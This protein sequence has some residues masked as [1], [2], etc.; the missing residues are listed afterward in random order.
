MAQVTRIHGRNE[1]CRI[2]PRVTVVTPTWQRHDLLLN[3]CIPS[4]QAQDYPSVEHLIIS[5][6]PDGA[7]ATRMITPWLHG[8]D[9]VWYRELPE[10]DTSEL[11]Y[12]HHARAYGCEIAQG[13]YITYCDDDDSLRPEHCRLLAAALD[14]NP[15]AGFAVSMMVSHGPHGESV[16]GAGPLAAGNV[17]T[18]MIM[19]RRG[20]LD[21]AT[22]DHTSSF[23]DWELVWAWMQAGISHVRVDQETS[24]V[25]PSL[26]R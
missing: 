2:I 25:W 24:D 15:E 20:I 21:V 12:G 22:W 23:E 8:W 4:V 17:G 9:R 19:H 13:A 14:A 11:H 26:Y 1:D 5:D 18:P 7:L 3:R 6:G 10:H 16:I